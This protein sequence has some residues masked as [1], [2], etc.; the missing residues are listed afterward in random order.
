MNHRTGSCL[1]RGAE[2]LAGMLVLVVSGFASAST[3]TLVDALG[4][5]ERSNASLQ[6]VIARQDAARAA[7]ITARQLPNPDVE[8]VAGPV[9]PR[10]IGG[11]DG[12]SLAV[13]LGQ[14]LDYAGLRAVRA[15][16]AD[17]GGDGAEAAVRTVRRSLYA[18]VRVHFY[19]VLQ[20][21]EQS[22]IAEEE[23]LALQQ[24]RERVNLRVQLGEAPRLD[25]IRA[26]TEV[27]NARRNRDSSVVRVEQARGA[28]ASL[29]G[30]PPG[31]LP[32]VEGTLPAL[33]AVPS[34]AAIR[35]QALRS[36]PELE[37]LE[38]EQRRARTRVELEQNL[39]K[40]QVRMLIGHDVEPDQTRWR[41]GLSLPLPLFNQRQGQIL[42]AQADAAFADAQFASRRQQLLGEIDYAIAGY[43]IAR[44]QVDAFESGLI[45]QAEQTVRVAEAAYR[46]GERGII[47][48]LDAQRT[49]RGVRQEYIN[50]LYEARYALIEVERLVGVD[51]L[52]GIR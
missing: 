48:Y 11:P 10:S 7:S 39:R 50:A 46:F 13:N 31:E 23:L 19:L 24:I 32:R 41:L 15:R 17:L 37:Q 51:V 30:M 42:E 3:L 12:H 18:S 4:I 1:K 14:P 2:A 8:V 27:L 49:L 6:A 35:D 43:S 44:Q 25:L 9:R 33:A 52:G 16:L 5:A 28:L 36:S 29:I 47:E 45:R 22:R 21:Q 26:D 40:P 20:R 34:L 38:A